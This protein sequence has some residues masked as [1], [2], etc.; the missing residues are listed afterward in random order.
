MRNVVGFIIF[1]VSAVLVWQGYENSRL[2]DETLEL[3]R[4]AVCS[5]YGGC[6]RGRPTKQLSD[7]TRRQ[8]EWLTP[9]WS[10]I[11]TCKRSAVFFG[12][13]SCGDVQRGELGIGGDY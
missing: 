12:P 10:Y 9:E 4:E 2:T 5:L 3:S 7:I 8:Y 1:A 6:A 13:W 11:T